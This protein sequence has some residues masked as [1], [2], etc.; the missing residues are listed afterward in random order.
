M[1]HSDEAEVIRTDLATFLIQLS[2]R[3]RVGAMALE[4]LARREGRPGEP[5]H[6]EVAE[7]G[8]SLDRIAGCL[9]T[10]SDSLCLDCRLAQVEERVSFESPVKS[11][12][13]YR[14]PRYK[15]RAAEPGRVGWET[16]LVKEPAPAAA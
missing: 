1:K 5:Q 11:K 12:H 2:L 9:K 15:G 6:D 8:T 16:P 4:A 7:V 10:A 13:A 3:L 14:M